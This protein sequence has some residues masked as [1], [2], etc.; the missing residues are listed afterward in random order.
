[1]L[2]SVVLLASGGAGA[3]A[4]RPCLPHCVVAELPH[5]AESEFIVTVPECK[6]LSECVSMKY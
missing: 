4:V 5:T 6:V 1:M 2:Y 3:V